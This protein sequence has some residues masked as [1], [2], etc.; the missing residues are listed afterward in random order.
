M[1]WVQLHPPGRLKN[2][3][4]L[5]YREKC[6]SATPRTQSAPQPVFFKKFL[7]Q[8]LLDG[9]D[10]EVY[11][12]G[13]VWPKKCTPADKM[14]ATPMEIKIIIRCEISQISVSII[15]FCRKSHTAFTIGWPWM[16]LNGIMSVIRRY[17]SYTEF[18]KLNPPCQRVCYKNVAKTKAFGNE[19]S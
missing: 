8:F 9:L 17:F 19:A 10:L 11:L 1:Q 13:L 3:S 14:L 12:D 15:H 7:G 5:F 18:V 4:G 16:T 6:V 2:F